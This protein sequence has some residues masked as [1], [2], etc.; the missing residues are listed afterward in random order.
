MDNHGLVTYKITSAV[1]EE[2]ES[3]YIL[4]AGYRYRIYFLTYFAAI[5]WLYERQFHPTGEYDDLHELWRK[6]E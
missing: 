1:T 5:G 6:A 3:Y 4:S 2:E